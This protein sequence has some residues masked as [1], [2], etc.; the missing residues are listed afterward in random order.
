MDE[1]EYYQCKQKTLSSSLVGIKKIYLDTRYWVIF[2]DVLAGKE[3]TE[4]DIKLFQKVFSLVQ[5]GQAICPYSEEVLLE[6]K[7]QKDPKTLKESINALDLLSKGVCFVSLDER[8]KHEIKN[9]MKLSNGGEL[10]SLGMP[11][12]IF[13]KSGYALGFVGP[14]SVLGEMGPTNDIVK[15]MI[16]FTWSLE[17][18]KMLERLG[19]DKFLRDFH[20]HDI[21]DVLNQGK[22]DN[23][24]ENTSYEQMYRSELGGIVDVYSDHIH[25]VWRDHCIEVGQETSKEMLDSGVS[26]LQKILFNGIEY[27]KLKMIVPTF[28]IL[29]SIHAFTR[30][31]KRRK[32]K[33]N[34]WSDFNH[35]IYALPYCDYFFTEGSLKTLLTT[36]KLQL[37]KLFK[38]LVFS[39]SQDAYNMLFKPRTNKNLQRKN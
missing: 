23:E 36:K 1:F 4:Y 5:A 38:C 16:D 7:K 24:N 31:D 10:E 15:S 18:S 37:D 39:D 17:L 29:A 27:G 26:S 2:R 12:N 3:R 25:A 6:F 34:D 9:L 32:Y 21:S 19:A 33:P 11:E 8:V 22:I 35:A 20:V 13:T 14:T 30:W 28:H